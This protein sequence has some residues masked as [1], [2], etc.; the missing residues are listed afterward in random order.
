MNITQTLGYPRIG[1]NR[2]MKRALEAYWQGAL[3]RDTLLATFA[4]VTREGWRAQLAA[5]ID[6]IGV[7][8]ETLY[9][10]VLDWSVRFDLIP[11]RF[12]DLSGLD[13]YF[14]MARGVPGIPAL[15][16]TKWFD[17]NYHYL[18]P[19]IDASITPQANFGDFL[20]LI[21]EAQ[22]MLGAHVAPIVLGP[23]TLLRLAR[24][25]V[26]FGEMLSA[27]LPLYRQLLDELK[28]LGVTEVQLHEPALVFGDAAALRPHVEKAYA[29]LSKVG[30]PLNL[31]TYFDDLG[32]NYPWIAALPVDVISLD[33]T[34]GDN[35]ALIQAH[36]WPQ[37]KTLG[38]GVVDA[39]SVWRVRPAETLALLETLRGYA[40]QMRIGPSSSLQFVPYTAA[41]E[42]ALPAALRGVLAFAEEKLAEVRLLATGETGGMD[43]PWAEFHAFA[44]A[45]P[46]VRSRIESLQPSDFTR[47]L[48]Y[49][50]RR[51]LQV[52]L[53]P[54]PTT[55]IGSFPQTPEVRRLRA[56]F[57]KGEISQAE[58]EAGIDAFIGYTIGV[59]DGLGLDMLVHGESE[60][61]DMVEY[62]AQKM[63]GFAFTQHGWV[64][65]FGS[66][67]V[68]PPIIY[69][70]V[71]RPQPMTVREFRVAQSYTQ[72]PVKG[73]LTGPVTILNWSYPRADVPRH[74]IAYQ[75]ALALR[76]EIADLEAAGARAIQVDEPALREG[77]P[78]KP[79][80]WDA[81][82]TWAVDAFRLTVGHAAPQ[83]QIHTHMCYSE[84]QDILPAI[85][86][87]DA[88]VISIENARSGDEML[89][90]LAEYG[91]PREV[92]PGV[93][94]I[95]SP[96]VPTVAFIAGK[97]ASFVQHLKP[98]QIWVNPDCG[99][100]TR[101]WDEV[102]PAL[103]NM[104]EAVQQ[105]RSKESET[106]FLHPA[107]LRGNHV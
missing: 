88:D 77:L 34:R 44:P 41:R 21:R 52:Q 38:A 84:F 16:M 68:R 47:A 45:D 55:T 97:L 107:S 96:V 12:R 95:H 73:M 20:A 14:A 82:L 62:F 56:R 33:F 70:D 91:Y 3:D 37:E 106:R 64:Q 5:G 53:P 71:S 100:K 78:L 42:K 54:F 57:N 48:P 72:K 89:R 86:R 99:L 50:E 6:L 18:A 74:I 11:P 66:R 94:D 35:L 93:Y 103:R 101:A 30:V 13:R 24:L 32:E 92:G 23:V 80:R 76:D 81:Y 87:L 67:Y 61:T 79:D 2:E 15:D 59:Q 40:P 22:A 58:Y 19:E 104:M 46:A 65:S 60:R 1:K 102:I 4:E 17:T 75:I 51:P 26:D 31:V 105:V 7:G 90:A 9:D 85:D 10:H 69:A 25:S 63:T 39:R 28:A 27:L 8:M 36:G 98:E 43:A 29:E 49:A 83:T